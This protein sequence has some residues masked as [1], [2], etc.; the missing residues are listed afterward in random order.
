VPLCMTKQLP[1]AF[2]F[3]KV[4]NINYFIALVL[5][6]WPTFIFFSTKSC[7]NDSLAYSEGCLLLSVCWFV[8]WIYYFYVFLC[9]SRRFTFDDLTS[10]FYF[11]FFLGIFGGFACFYKLRA[12][13]RWLFL[14][15]FYLCNLG[16]FE[17]APRIFSGIVIRSIFNSPSI[18]LLLYVTS[19]FFWVTADLFFFFSNFYYSYIINDL[20]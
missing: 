15:L 20:T 7:S 11:Y 17:T 4:D 12:S 3:I 19:L 2:P 8:Y 6:F 16:A 10:M 14:E 5:T 1:S 9:V 13:E 18:S